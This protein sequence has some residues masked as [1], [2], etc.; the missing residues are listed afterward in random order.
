MAVSRLRNCPR[1]AFVRA[2]EVIVKASM[3][4]TKILCKVWSNHHRLLLIARFRTV[5]ERWYPNSGPKE[6]S[7]IIIPCCQLELS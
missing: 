7:S 2:Q 5:A 6:G 3:V 4:S 1:M